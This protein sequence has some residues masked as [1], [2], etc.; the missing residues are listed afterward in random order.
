WAARA[1][2]ARRSA[3]LVPGGRRR[4]ARTHPAKPAVGTV[5]AARAA[6]SRAAGRRQPREAGRRG[7]PSGPRDDER[8]AS[9][10]GLDPAGSPLGLRARREAA[11]PHLVESLVLHR[12]RLV[13]QC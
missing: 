13:S 10:L 12:D 5:R 6:P 11:G 7:W 9:E 3:I 1:R 4:A 8:A 2:P